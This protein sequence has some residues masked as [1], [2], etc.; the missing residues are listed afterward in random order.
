MGGG[1][2]T[3][4]GN[5]LGYPDIKL[6]AAEAAALVT[7]G[8]PWFSST[9][10]PYAAA[11]L[12][13][14]PLLHGLLA[15]TSPL[16]RP[17]VP[18]EDESSSWFMTKYFTVRSP[19]AWVVPL[20]S[21][22][23]GASTR[24]ANGVLPEFNDVDTFSGRS[25]L[26]KT[27][28][29]AALNVLSEGPIWA[30]TD[31]AT[32]MALHMTPV[33]IQ[34]ADGAFVAPTAE[35]MQAAV[36]TMKPDADG[37]LLPDPNAAAPSVGAAAAGVEPY[38][39]T[40]VEYAM[41]PSE[42]LV[43]P[44]GCVACTGSQALLTK[45]L[46]YVTT[47]GQKNL[48]PG[49]A[50]LPDSLVVQAQSR[51]ALVGTA[52]VT[53]VCAGVVSGLSN[54]GAA[55]G[56]IGGAGSK[57]FGSSA[58]SLNPLGVSTPAAAGAGAKAKDVTLA[59]PAF[60]GH[61]L[62]D[63]SDGIV[64]LLGIVLLTS[65]AA[66]VTSGRGAAN[67]SVAGAGTVGAPAPSG[68]PR[69]R[70][71]QLVGLWVVVGAVGLGLVIYQM[72]PLLQQRDQHDLLKSYRTEVRHAANETSGLPGAS[73]PT[74]APV[75]GSAVGVVEIGALRAQDVVVEGVTP[76]DTSKGPGHVPGTA[77]LGQPGNSVVVARRNAF[78]GPFGDLSSV[79]RGSRILITTTQ[80]QSVYAVRT[81]HTQDVVDGDGSSQ[82]S[83]LPVTT[84]AVPPSTTSAGSTTTTVKGTAT[85]ATKSASPK[86]I[87]T[88]EL[89]GPSTDDRLTLVTSA[90]R[91][92]LNTS[93]ATVVVAKMI[94]KPFER[95]PQGGL[96]SNETGRSG[97]SGVW[98][99]VI[100]VLLLYVGA[101]AAAVLLYRKLRFRV[102]YLLTIAP[103]VALTIVVGETL[104]RLFPAWM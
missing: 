22:A 55:G 84:A 99:S 30:V 38:P 16:A 25:T 103:L 62:P 78:G 42:P 40:Y 37:Y 24:F 59:I 18:S 32:A 53:G 36:A 77:G 5:K 28:E 95:T 47:D 76:S 67:L 60:V 8:I 33:S 83:S 81:V 14:N 2:L 89:Y 72:G 70:P 57:G 61:N 21:T 31:L 45:W 51:I 58:S 73:T 65:L 88:E 93:S 52:P 9:D 4:F 86:E 20:T 39:L 74:Q 6:T 29:R 17:F 79:K 68:L 64:A 56:A 34:N 102:A 43:D 23:R 48:P 50:A 27:S 94:G 35:S 19:D 97:E 101:I 11:V 46:Q 91:S 85:A 26:Y 90:S 54:G 80:G 104:S 7:G 98:P 44:S 75:E 13:R 69:I 12:A 92:P 100:L 10:N 41:A 71:A 49:F 15:A 87:T 96:T 82:A 3:D 1:Y 66:W 63:T